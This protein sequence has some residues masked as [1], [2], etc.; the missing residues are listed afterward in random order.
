M[1][2]NILILLFTIF[3]SYNLNAIE[4]S[5]TVISDNEK[6]ITSRYMGFIKKVYVNEGDF[7]HKGQ[8]L[9]EID[10]S[11]IDS[12]KK[13]ALLNIQIQKNNLENIDIN[14]KRYKRLYEKDLVPKYDLEQLQLK[15]KNA[16]NML[17]IAKTKLKEVRQQY[18]YLKIKAPNDALVIKKSIKSGEMAMPASPALIL[19]DLSS[20]KIKAE[21]AESLLGKIKIGQSVDLFIESINYKTKG[22]ILAIIPNVQNMTHSFVLKIGFNSENKKIYPGMYSNIFINL[23]KENVQ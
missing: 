20:L 14:Y 10:S 16:K 13:E 19:S 18:Q 2:K 1:K 23:D 12:N 4:I 17:N 22:E 3:F 9:Y 11:N 7:V 15:L 8:L 5:G 21:I 6:I